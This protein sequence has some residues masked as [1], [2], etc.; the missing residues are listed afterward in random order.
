MKRPARG[1]ES[2]A[3]LFLNPGGESTVGKK[4]RQPTTVTTAAPNRTMT[5]ETGKYTVSLIAP[6]LTRQ[7]RLTC[8]PIAPRHILMDC[9]GGKY[10][11]GFGGDTP[12]AASPTTVAPK[13]PG[14]REP[15][16]SDQQALEPQ[17]AHEE[18]WARMGAALK[19]FAKRFPE[20][21]EEDEKP[22]FADVFTELQKIPGAT[23]DGTRE[24]LKE[25]APQLIKQRG[26]RKPKN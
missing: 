11:V 1:Y 25:F 13:R 21:P 24:A 3:G 18:L 12:A 5:L 20:K 4:R 22:T 15:E 26:Y 14:G 17:L 2:D 16:L 10:G 8:S 23:R 19:N 6:S 7:R 9:V